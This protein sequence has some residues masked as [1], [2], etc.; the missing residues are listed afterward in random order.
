MF[1]CAHGLPLSFSRQPF[2]S[3]W[4]HYRMR[5]VSRSA[6]VVI[7]RFNISQVALSPQLMFKVHLVIFSVL[8][9]IRF[10]LVV[11]VCN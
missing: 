3:L 2:F 11:F 5:S 4:D 9:L 6:C 8:S 7:F 10:G 1:A